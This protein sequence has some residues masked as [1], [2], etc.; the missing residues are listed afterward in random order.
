M[1]LV[2]EFNAIP[3]TPRA[4]RIGQVLEITVG[5]TLLILAPALIGGLV[6]WLVP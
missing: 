4:K 5:V 2:D 3:W 6:N 1:R